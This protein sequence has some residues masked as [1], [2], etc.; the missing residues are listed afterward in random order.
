MI[1]PI[2]NRFVAG[3]TMAGA[4][5]HVSMLNDRGVGGILNLLGEHYHDA[6]SAVEDARVYRELIRAV[7]DSGVDASISVKPSQI[8]IDVGAETF[9]QNLARIVDAA[10]DRDVFVWV[11]MEDHTTT[12]ATL[13][14]FERA[15]TE[16]R[17]GVGLAIQANLK[18][19]RDDLERLAEL[20]GS[21]RLVKGAYDEPESVAYQQ[22]E[23]VDEAYRDHLEF[24]FEEF[25]DGVA[26]GSH[27]PAMIGHAKRL[28]D[29]YGTP[30]EVQMLMGVRDDAQF[31]LADEGCEVNQY[32]PYGDKWMLYFYRR[33]RERK[34][35]ALF[36]LRA[37]A[38]V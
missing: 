24:M 13:D 18:R 22:K 31:T 14:A 34:E 4:I 28:H 30:F 19:T 2:A 8:G 23:R 7:D 33:I 26:V 17:G 20:P 38:G 32:V 9:S 35:N 16:H 12:D 10:A 25:D 37:I 27:D 5:D 36:A 6:E 21:V 29:E 3:T 11:D 1:P 15:A